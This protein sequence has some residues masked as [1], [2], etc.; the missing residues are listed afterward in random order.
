MQCSKG[1]KSEFFKFGAVDVGYIG[2]KSSHEVI[3]LDRRP[4][5]CFE[6]VLVNFTNLKNNN[7][8]T[9]E[10]EVIASGRRTEL[11]TETYVFAT[12]ARFHVHNF[13]LR[14]R[15]KFTWKNMNE[16]EYNNVITWGIHIFRLCDTI[17][18][19]APDLIKTVEAFVGGIGTNPKI[20][21]FGSKPPMYQQRIN[22]DFIEA[23]TNFRWK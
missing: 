20:P 13:I 2:N 17:A 23:G 19:W 8:N 10:V 3:I 14:N 5:D 1:P 22:V 9:I 21:F 15:H 7:I 12:A 11:C 16:N 18:H 6:K 4:D